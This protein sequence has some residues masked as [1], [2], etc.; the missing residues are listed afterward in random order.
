M[1]EDPIGSGRPT[2]I[3]WTVAF[4]RFWW[5]FLIGDTP[6]L[7]VGPVA[8]IVAV[9]VICLQPGLRTAAAFLMPVLV[10]AVLLASVG[11]AARRAS[12]DQSQ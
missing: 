8:V 2:V 5:D 6:E 7:F 9:A 3:R 1:A 11:R 10:T 12:R 4:G